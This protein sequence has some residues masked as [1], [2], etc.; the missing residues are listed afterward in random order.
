MPGGRM[1]D[2]EEYA[3]GLHGCAMG[4]AGGGG[5]I[6]VFGGVMCFETADWFS[7]SEANAR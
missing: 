3:E 4:D 2:D 5:R 1:V 6:E 7:G